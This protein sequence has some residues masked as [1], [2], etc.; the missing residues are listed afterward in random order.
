[1]PLTHTAIL[2]ISIRHDAKLRETRNKRNGGE[3]REGG[4][5]STEG[6][7]EG[8]NPTVIALTTTRRLHQGRRGANR[9][10]EGLRRTPACPSDTIFNSNLNILQSFSTIRRTVESFFHRSLFSLGKYIRIYIRI[11]RK[12]ANSSQRRLIANRGIWRV[13]KKR[14]QGKRGNEINNADETM[15]N[16]ILCSG[17][18][19]RLDLRSDEIICRFWPMGQTLRCLSDRPSRKYTTTFCPPRSNRPP[20]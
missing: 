16:C 14:V 1:M 19:L 2:K 12:F 11:K 13:E 8:S 10:D 15:H 4:C 20:L 18:L 17:E 3:G 5:R 7:K 6:E 9:R